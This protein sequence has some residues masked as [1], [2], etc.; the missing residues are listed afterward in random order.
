MVRQRTPQG[1]RVAACG[2]LLR[3][4]QVRL[5]GIQTRRDL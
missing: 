2:G 3:G 1:C 5:T 4:L